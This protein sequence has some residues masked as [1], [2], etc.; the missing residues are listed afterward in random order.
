MI[1]TIYNDMST[2][3]H[4]HMCVEDK[5]NSVVIESTTI[6]NASRHVLGEKS[7]QA[8]ERSHFIFITFYFFLSS[9]LKNDKHMSDFNQTEMA[10]SPAQN[11]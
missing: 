3:T 10:I 1:L 7:G 5:T 2:I 8:I 9:A 4:P 6:S 11:S